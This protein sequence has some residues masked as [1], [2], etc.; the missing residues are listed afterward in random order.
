M[1]NL[2]LTIGLILLS[3]SAFSQSSNEMDLFIHKVIKAKNIVS[4]TLPGYESEKLFFVPKKGMKFKILDDKIILKKRGKKF[5]IPYVEVETENISDEHSNRK[6]TFF[7]QSKSLDYGSVLYKRHEIHE[8]GMRTTYSFT[9]DNTTYD[10][11]NF[12]ANGTPYKDQL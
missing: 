5:V 10:F 1:R 6:N 7:Y 2:T 3:L 9:I 4:Y 11:V 8:K 12:Y